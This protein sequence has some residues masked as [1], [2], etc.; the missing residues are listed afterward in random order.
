MPAQHHAGHNPAGRMPAQSHAGCAEAADE[1]IDDWVNMLKSQLLG[2]LREQ[3]TCTMAAAAGAGALHSP[4]GARSSSNA[5]GLMP[6]QQ[7]M[8]AQGAQQQ[9]LPPQRPHR[10]YHAAHPPRPH[11]AAQVMHHQ[12]LRVAS[13]P[14]CRFSASL[15]STIDSITR[16]TVEGS[17]SPDFPGF[18]SH[19]SPDLAGSA[20]SSSNNNLAVLAGRAH[21]LYSDQSSGSAGLN[22]HSQPLPTLALQEQ[23]VAV[24]GGLKRH[25]SIDQDQLLLSLLNEIVPSRC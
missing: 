22:F 20:S 13:A 16:T 18:S 15:L 17:R 11:P 24:H 9:H 5:A 10:H 12:R 14:P 2:C 7:Q 21:S 25:N 19:S 4:A 3:Q 1:G 8:Q 6:M 23:G